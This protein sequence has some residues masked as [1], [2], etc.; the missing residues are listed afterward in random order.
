MALVMLPPSALRPYWAIW[1]RAGTTS[2][3]E[4]HDHRTTSPLLAE[5]T[6]RSR[7][8]QRSEDRRCVS[9]EPHTP[10]AHEA[11]SRVAPE[12]AHRAIPG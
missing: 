6:T 2:T 5:V 10:K 9:A 4:P 1:I 11:P 8:G 12:G 3:R 7:R